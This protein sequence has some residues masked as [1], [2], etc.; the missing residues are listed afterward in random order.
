MSM[1]LR[2][3]STLPIFYNETRNE[4]RLNFFDKIK[5]IYI[6]QNNHTQTPPATSHYNN[7]RARLV[8]IINFLF[9]KP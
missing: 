2:E 3:I 5:K 8:L 4:C 7:P 1:P 9:E 6:I